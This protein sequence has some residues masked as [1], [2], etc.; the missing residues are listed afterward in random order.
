MKLLRFRLISFCAM[1]VLA[2]CGGSSS[3]TTPPPP[4]PPVTGKAYVAVVGAFSIM[5]FPAGGNGNISPENSIKLPSEAPGFL[6]VDVAHDRLVTAANGSFPEVVFVDNA[7]TTLQP[8][9]AISGAATTMLFAGRIAIDT[10]IDL[11]NVASG[12]SG[13]LYQAIFW[14]LVPL[15][16]L[17]AT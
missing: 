6:A 3:S 14:Y 10:L 1:L 5:R 13:S 15:Q 12:S 16:L 11:V 4:P 7:S 9:R 2:G 17:A 8:V